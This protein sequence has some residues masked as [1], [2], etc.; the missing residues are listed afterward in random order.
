[1]QTQTEQIFDFLLFKPKSTDVWGIL[2]EFLVFRLR[3]GM[4]I[5]EWG[6]F[7]IGAYV[8]RYFLNYY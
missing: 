8:S 6:D 1:V 2:K 5:P 3:G 4:K 7:G